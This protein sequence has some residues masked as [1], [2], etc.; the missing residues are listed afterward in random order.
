MEKGSL[1]ER[2]YKAL[3]KIRFAGNDANPI[4]IWMQKVAAHAMDPILWPDPGLH[5]SK[6]SRDYRERNA[7]M[8]GPLQPNPA[9]KGRFG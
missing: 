8:D 2:Y 9:H 6:E 4:A 3:E 5:E 7:L 1:E